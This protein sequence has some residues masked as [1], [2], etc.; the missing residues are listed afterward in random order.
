MRSEKGFTLIELVIAIALLIILASYAV[1]SLQTYTVNRNL[2]NAAR[3]LAADFTQCQQKAISEN[4]IYQISFDI[5]GGSYT[6]TPGNVVKRPSSFGADISILNASFGSP[7]APT[8]NVNPRGTVAPLGS[9][10]TL[11]LPSGSVAV[12][13]GVILQNNRGSV[14][15]VMVNTVGRTNVNFYIK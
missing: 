14:A 7:A 9:T 13:D 6:I 8:V 4:V 15:T 10:G 1:L 5:A 12:G 2:K 3:E 11:L